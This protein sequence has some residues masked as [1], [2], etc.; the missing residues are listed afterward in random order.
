MA[1]MVVPNVAQIEFNERLKAKVSQ[2]RSNLTGATL[3]YVDMYA[4]K[5]DLIANAIDLRFTKWFTICCG[6]HDLNNDLYCG[7]QGKINGSEVF[8]GSCKEMFKE[9]KE[10]DLMEKK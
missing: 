1:V 10:K 3:T 6:Y 7:N 9:M 8:A 2:L 4:A 5:Y